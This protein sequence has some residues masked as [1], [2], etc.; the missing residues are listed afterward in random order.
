MKDTIEKL[1]TLAIT[2]FDMSGLEACEA[3]RDKLIEKL[4]MGRK[5]AANAVRLVAAEMTGHEFSKRE[6]A[7]MK[8]VSSN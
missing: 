5:Q 2:E 3:V 1:L 8:A 6:L 4:G 7:A